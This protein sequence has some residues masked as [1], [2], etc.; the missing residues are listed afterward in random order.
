MLQAIKTYWW[1]IGLRGLILMVFGFTALYFPEFGMDRLLYTV[2]GCL[3][4]LAMLQFIFSMLQKYQNRRWVPLFTFSIVDTMLTVLI[5]AHPKISAYWLNTVIAFW[6]L[7]LAFGVIYLAL[8]KMG[9]R[10]LLFTLAGGSIL[11]SFYLFNNLNTP[12]AAQS[13]LI[14]AFTLTLGTLASYY[15][16]RLLLTKTRFSR[17]E[18]S[19]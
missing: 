10:P 14:G 5:F 6:S 4:T 1:S 11:F 3:G 18:H 12:F 17:P 7:F 16:I 8:R 9:N 19:P 2:G 15:G 13:Q